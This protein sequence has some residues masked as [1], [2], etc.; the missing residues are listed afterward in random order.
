M[1]G[2]S[3]NV[4][5]ERGFSLTETLVATALLA[6]ALVASAHLFALGTRANFSARTTTFATLL[7]QQK[8]EQLRA[9]TWG[10]DESGLPI[11]DLTS[12]TTVDPVQPDGGLGLTPSPPD[13]LLANVDGFVDWV[14]REGRALGG[15]LVPPEGAAYVRRWSIEPLPA[16]PNNTL[17]IQVFVFRVGTRPA[18]RDPSGPDVLERMP[19]EARLVTVKTRKAR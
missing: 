3:S 8:I 11:T 13:S 10:F 9:L 17:I 7:A 4:D 2:F 12:D 18:E 14:D 15:G 19:D 6:T 16:N 1:A 5:A